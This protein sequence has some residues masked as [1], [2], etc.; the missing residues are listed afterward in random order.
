MYKPNK[1]LHYSKFEYNLCLTCVI[2]TYI[3]PPLQ[4]CL[5]LALILNKPYVFSI[6]SGGFENEEKIAEMKWV[7]FMI[8]LVYALVVGADE[9]ARLEGRLSDLRRSC[10]TGREFMRFQHQL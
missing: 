5:N 10:V 2:F 1:P 7:S 8:A 9:V 4:F 6:T 3:Y